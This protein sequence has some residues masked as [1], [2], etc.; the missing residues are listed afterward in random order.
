MHGASSRLVEVDGTGDRRE[1]SGCQKI[2]TLILLLLSIGL[3][4]VF[5][6]CVSIT[7]YS[8]VK[9]LLF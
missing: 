4:I 6:D 2:Y 7:S 3:H 5:G 9:A 8:R 1:D